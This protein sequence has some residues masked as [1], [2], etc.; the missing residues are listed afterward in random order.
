MQQV[1]T[2]ITAFLTSLASVPAIATAVCEVRSGPTTAAL[3]ELYTSEGCSS[4]PPADR[5]LTELRPSPG[6]VPLSLHVGYWDHLGWRDPFAQEDFARRQDWLAHRS[7]PG[8]VYTPQ[9]FVNGTAVRPAALDEQVRRSNAE[10]A[11]ASIRLEARPLGSAALLVSAGAE[12]AVDAAA[13]YLGLTESGLRNEVGAG[14]NRG[15]SLRHDHVVRVWIGP[16][17]MTDGR[18]EVE[19]R[20]VLDQT[21]QPAQLGLL[22]FVQDQVS[23][24]VLQAVGVD[25]CTSGEG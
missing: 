1:G 14:E 19:R 11:R 13:F 24:R 7:R 16:L 5:L 20:I 17:A 10:P 9:F 18:V 3:V 21:W 15:R 2:L 23:G 25:Q 6:L 22:G 12:S 4:C 8:A